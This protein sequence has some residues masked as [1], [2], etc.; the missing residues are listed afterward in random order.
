MPNR[1]TG[2][3]LFDYV[4]RAGPLPD[5]EAKFVAYQALQALKVTY[6]LLPWMPV[7][8]TNRLTFASTTI[9]LA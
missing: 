7:F 3:D 8:I 1:L 6:T 2:G 5:M 9:V 4:V